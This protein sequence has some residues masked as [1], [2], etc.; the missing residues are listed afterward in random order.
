MRETD[1]EKERETE[2]YIERDRET[3]MRETERGR[4]AV[5]T[6]VAWRRG[7]ENLHG[8]GLITDLC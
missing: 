4:K 1:R 2:R 6:G 8:S 3:D 7:S 5:V